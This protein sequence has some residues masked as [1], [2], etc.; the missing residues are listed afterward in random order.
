MMLITFVIVSGFLPKYSD[1][2]PP[3]WMMV[4]TS[5][6]GLATLMVEE[7][8]NG[9]YELQPIALVII[10]ATV[11]LTI[12]ATCSQ[13]GMAYLPMSEVIDH[14]D[15]LELTHFL[16]RLAGR[17]GAICTIGMFHAG[18]QLVIYGLIRRRLLL[19]AKA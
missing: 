5:L 14:H 19:S 17:A 3:I 15:P 13:V 11:M 8:T 7:R 6:S 9:R 10:G 1:F 18:I 12:A 2:G 4:V 16:R